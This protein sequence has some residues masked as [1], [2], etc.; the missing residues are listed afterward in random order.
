MEFSQAK[1]TQRE[2]ITALL[3]HGSIREGIWMLACDYTFFPTNALVEATKERNG[4]MFVCVTAIGLQRVV[5]GQVMG[6][7]IVTVDAAEVNPA[8]AVFPGGG[9]GSSAPN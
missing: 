8:L 9:T 1:F 2:V 6:D 5:P 4:G 7:S 3:R